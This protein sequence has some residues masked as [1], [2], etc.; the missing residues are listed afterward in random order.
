MAK[1]PMPFSP[2]RVISLKGKIGDEYDKYMI[3]SATDSSLILGIS[4]GKISALNDSSFVK[5]EPTIHAG[6][7]EDGSYI[8]ITESS[9]IHVRSHLGVPNT[10]W[11]SDPGRK[12]VSACSNSRQVMIQVEK[13]QL[14]YFEV[15]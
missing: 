14:I 1:S 2:K 10:K 4:E 3:V 11:Q 12:I 13:D 5:G 9:I 15:D 8:Q 7:M 6:V